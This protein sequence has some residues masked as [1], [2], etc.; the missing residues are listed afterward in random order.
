M[1][2]DE[3]PPL[4]DFEE[5]I[6]TISYNHKPKNTP[7]QEDYTKPNARHIEDEIKQQQ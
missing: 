6:K 2:D 1:S 7:S 4:D 5:D 3:M